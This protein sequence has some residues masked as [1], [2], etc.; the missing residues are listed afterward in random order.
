MTAPN[1]AIEVGGQGA[2]ATSTSIAK[3]SGVVSGQAALVIYNTKGAVVPATSTAGWTRATYYSTTTGVALFTSTDAN[4][5]TWPLVVT[6]TSAIR[7]WDVLI[8]DNAQN[9]DWRI[10]SRGTGTTSATMSVITPA[11]G[12]AGYDMLYIA[13][14]FNSW[15]TDV[16]P[17]GTGPPGYANKTA[18]G[19]GT[20]NLGAGQSR[21]FKTVINAGATETP[22][23]W[24]GF[25]SGAAYRIMTIALQG[26]ASV[27]VTQKVAVGTTLLDG[28]D[29]LRIGTSLVDAVY[30]GT[31]LIYGD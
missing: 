15:G 30:L 11:W 17:T 20:S 3:P 21:A 2:A 19:Q 23:S 9:L 29:D 10:A 18:N 14:A 6:H 24:S 31:T 28:V 12:S 5:A 16:N 13:V 7:V 22:G 8:L 25:S 27:S 1:K 4:A 26:T